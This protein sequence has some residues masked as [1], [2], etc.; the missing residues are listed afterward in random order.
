MILF[1]FVFIML[2]V[3]VWFCSRSPLWLATFIDRHVRGDTDT[4]GYRLSDQLSGIKFEYY[5]FSEIFA[6]VPELERE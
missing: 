2:A 1:V 3:G 6:A 5:F 4:S